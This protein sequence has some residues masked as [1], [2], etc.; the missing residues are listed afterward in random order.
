MIVWYCGCLIDLFYLL[1][2]HCWCFLCFCCFLCLIPLVFAYLVFG[3]GLGL[4]SWWVVVLFSFANS[5]DD[6]FVFFVWIVLGCFDCLDLFGLWFCCVYLLFLGLVL[7]FVV[8][9]FAWLIC[10]RFDLCCCLLADGCLN[11]CVVRIRFVVIEDGLMVL[12]YCIAVWCL[13]FDCLVFVYCLL[14]SC[15]VWFGLLLLGC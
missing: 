1:A 14:F 2:F 10:V 3:L 4:C 8:A 7:R 15:S 13:V 5:V 11:C 6:W 9:L 12:L